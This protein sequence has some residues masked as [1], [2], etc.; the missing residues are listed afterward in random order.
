M[1]KKYLRKNEFRI[2]FNPLH[3]GKDVEPHPAYI[4]AKHGHKFK[5][6]SITHSKKTT[7]GFD[8]FV[9]DEN[10]NKLSKDK[11]QTRISPPFWQNEKMFSENKLPNFRFSKQIRNKIKKFNKKNK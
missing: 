7:D 11:R 3:F 9:I 4:T 5:A 8:T 2:D 10:P 1:S 6:N